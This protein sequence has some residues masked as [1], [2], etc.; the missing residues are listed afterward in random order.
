MSAGKG[1]DVTAGKSVRVNPADETIQVGPVT[2][3][4]DSL[5]PAP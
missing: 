5:T 1:A 2:I 3:R 4:R